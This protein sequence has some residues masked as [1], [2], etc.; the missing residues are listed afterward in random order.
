[1]DEP[2]TIGGRISEPPVSTDAVAGRVRKIKLLTAPLSSPSRRGV[3]VC[4]PVATHT[5][6]TLIG[7]GIEGH[8]P[9]E[10]TKVREPASTHASASDGST[11]PRPGAAGADSSKYPPSHGS[12][13]TTDAVLLQ[14][15]AWMSMKF[16]VV[17]ASP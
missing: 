11:S 7:L 16:R 10:H 6:E 1:M 5:T 12:M 8:G 17:L 3:A 15:M 4:A 14:P 2:V 9:R 13:N